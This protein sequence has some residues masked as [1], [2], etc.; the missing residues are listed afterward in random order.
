MYVT[1]RAADRDAFEWVR[2][3]FWADHSLR[4]GKVQTI[5]DLAPG[6]QP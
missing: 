6:N 2:M 1:D 5:H 3:K 4:D